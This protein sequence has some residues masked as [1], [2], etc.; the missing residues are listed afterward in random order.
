MKV[1][2]LIVGGGFAGCVLAWN[3]LKIGKKVFILSNPYSN[4]ASTVAAGIINPITGQRFVKSWR[5][6]QF[7]AQANEFYKDASREVGQELFKPKKIIRFF[8]NEHE[9]S[10]WDKKKTQEDISLFV[11]REWRGQSSYSGV[12]NNLGGV[13]IDGGGWANIKKFIKHC[14]NILAQQDAIRYEHALSEDFKFTLG[15]AVW[16]DQISCNQVVCCTGYQNKSPWFQDLRWK[17]AKGEL[18]TLRM[19]EMPVSNIY[20]QGIF[21][22]PVGNGIVKVGA[23]YSWDQ[24][25]AITTDYARSHLEGELNRMFDFAYKILNHEAAVRP[26]LQDTRPVV[27]KHPEIPSLYLLNGLGS[28][29]GLWGPLLARQLINFIEHDVPLDP[30]LDL[31]RNSV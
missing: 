18:L 22:L 26:I 27:G 16:K 14:H 15:Q 17:P 13:C 24:L 7:F 5:W 29:G 31:L 20:S 12:K 21:I 23:T 25:D 6:E 2:Y 10:K 30:A 1:D 19:N 28:K 11:T 3:L 4:N 8:K 9:L